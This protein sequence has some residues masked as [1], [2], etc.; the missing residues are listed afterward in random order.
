MTEDGRGMSTREIHDRLATI[1]IH[2]ANIYDEVLNK[3]EISW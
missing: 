2:G 1:K 3:V